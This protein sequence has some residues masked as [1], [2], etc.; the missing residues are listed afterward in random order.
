MDCGGSQIACQLAR[1]ADAL[2]GFDSNAFLSTL[3]ATL[4]GAG[5]AAWVSFWLTE[6]ERPQPMWTVE[7]DAQGQARDGSFT[8]RIRVTNVGDGTAYHPRITVSGTGIT[9]SRVG[10]EAVLEP[11]EI[12]TA[13]CGAPGTGRDWMDPKTLQAVDDRKVQWPADAA[14]LIEWHQPPRR[15]HTK[16]HRMDIEAPSF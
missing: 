9:G 3:L 2:S 8:V 7:S 13:W 16:R 4:V 5:V 14:V 10:V 6:R 12:V 15:K 1:I 11:G